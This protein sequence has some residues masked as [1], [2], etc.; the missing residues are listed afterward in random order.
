MQSGYEGI[1]ASLKQV[2]QDLLQ[3]NEFLVQDRETLLR[4]N[5]ELRKKNESLSSVLDVKRRLG[6]TSNDQ[7]EIFEIL[8]ESGSVTAGMSKIEESCDEDA[9]AEVSRIL[10]GDPCEHGGLILNR[11]EFAIASNPL[12]YNVSQMEENEISMSNIG[13]TNAVPTRVQT[14]GLARENVFLQC[15]SR[16]VEGV[17]RAFYLSVLQRRGTARQLARLVEELRHDITAVIYEPYPTNEFWTEMLGNFLKIVHEG[18]FDTQ[19]DVLEYLK[20]HRLIDTL[21]VNCLRSRVE[22][23]FA[24]RDSFEPPSVQEL[25]GSLANEFS[26]RMEAGEGQFVFF[27]REVREELLLTERASLEISLNNKSENKYYV[28]E[29]EPSFTI[30]HREETLQLPFFIVIEQDAGLEQEIGLSHYHIND[31]PH[32]FHSHDRNRSMV[33]HEIEGG[34]DGDHLANI[35]CILNERDLNAGDD[36]MEGSLRRELA[37]ELGKEKQLTRNPGHRRYNNSNKKSPYA[38]QEPLSSSRFFLNRV[39]SKHSSLDEAYE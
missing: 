35:A 11:T 32:P 23:L 8:V 37:L 27:A 26:L 19:S 14:P 7:E 36:F 1:I 9:E 25:L 13:R 33:E 38:Y 6:D 16:R 3:R 24:C 17:I 21:L 29:E 15:S 4:E 34:S 20:A 18:H 28:R 31:D 5:H 12:S 22:F 30:Y 2:I 10:V 39:S